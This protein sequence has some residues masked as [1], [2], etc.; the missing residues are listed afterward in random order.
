VRG[1][2]GVSIRELP[3]SPERVWQA[4]QQAEASDGS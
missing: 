2:T 3:L 1:A 4:L